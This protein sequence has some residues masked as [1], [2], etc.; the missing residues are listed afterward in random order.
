MRQRQ[1]RLWKIDGAWRAAVAAWASALVA[2]CPFAV[3]PRSMNSMVGIA[4][5]SLSVDHC[6]PPLPVPFRA[7]RPVRAGPG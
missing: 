6:V 4:A 7:V 5:S 3:A 1:G 2:A